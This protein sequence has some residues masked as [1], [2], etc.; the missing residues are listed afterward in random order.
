MSVLYKVRVVF[1]KCGDDLNEHGSATYDIKFPPAWDHI[2]INDKA[3]EMVKDADVFFYG[4]LAC[5]NDVSKQSLFSILD[6]NDHMFKVFDVNLRKA[7]Y[8]IEILGKLMLKAAFIKFNDEEIMEIALALGFESESLED[9]I[10]FISEKTNTA[11]ICMTLGKHGSILLWNG[12][13]SEHPGYPVMVVDTV[14][15]GDSF[16]ASLIVDI[17]SGKD[18]DQALDFASAIG[19]LVAGQSGANPKIEKADVEA[20]IIHKTK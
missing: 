2:A 6:S 16:L 7:F 20:F 1:S 19:A 5:R 3:I 12:H 4:S 14:G 9:N 8:N 13:I 10:S 11:C 15:A 18:P 17:W